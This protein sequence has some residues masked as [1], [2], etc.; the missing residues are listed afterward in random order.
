MVQVSGNAFSLS[1][2]NVSAIYFRPIV[3]Y[4]QIDD[5]KGIAMLLI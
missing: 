4:V 2:G 5:Q 1:I 3:V